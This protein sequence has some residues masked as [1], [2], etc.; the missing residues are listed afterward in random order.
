MSGMALKCAYKTYI[1]C[2]YYKPDNTEDAILV[3]Q[4]QASY[5]LRFEVL[6]I[7]TTNSTV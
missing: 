5:M 3:Q 1:M 2:I 4:S 7:V 6:S